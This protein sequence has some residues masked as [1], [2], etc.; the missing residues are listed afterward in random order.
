M[1]ADFAKHEPS[2]M[3]LLV[4]HVHLRTSGDKCV[5]DVC[6]RVECTDGVYFEKQKT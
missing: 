2:A 1:E 4:H 6:G 3:K 5:V